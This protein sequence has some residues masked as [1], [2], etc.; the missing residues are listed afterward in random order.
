[1]SWYCGGI[2]PWETV[3]KAII[4]AGVVVFFIVAIKLAVLHYQA[5]MDLFD[6]F[7]YCVGG[8]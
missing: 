2:V 4:Y 6:S 8:R 5:C 7:W 3:E 1:M